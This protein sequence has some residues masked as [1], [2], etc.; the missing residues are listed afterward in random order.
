MID[1][2]NEEVEEIKKQNKERTNDEEIDLPEVIKIETQVQCVIEWKK[3]IIY[4]SKISL[5]DFAIKKLIGRGK[6]GKVYLVNCKL[7]NRIFA[8]KVIKKS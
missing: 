7:S 6:Y 3:S 2:W 5:Q 8:M 4:S 1:W